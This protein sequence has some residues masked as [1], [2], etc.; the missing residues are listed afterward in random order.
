MH[1][2]ICKPVQVGKMGKFV[3]RSCVPALE[4]QQRLEKERFM[5]RFPALTITML[6]ATVLFIAQP[7]AMSA[8][9]AIAKTGATTSIDPAALIGT[10]LIT[11]GCGEGGTFELTAQGKIITKEEPGSSESEFGTYKAIDG[12]ITVTAIH[13]GKSESQTC[14]YRVDGDSLTLIEKM[15]DV[16]VVNEGDNL[17][18]TK[19]KRQ[20]SASAASAPRSLP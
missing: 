12:R 20:E 2:L 4:S 13:D 6:V 8:E 3:T 11:E 16:I 9:T 1:R 10:W 14:D 15:D 7:T 5:P 18:I 19:L 17:H